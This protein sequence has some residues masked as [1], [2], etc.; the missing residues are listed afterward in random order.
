M[1]IA[2]VT[3]VVALDTLAGAQAI[4]DTIG[5]FKFTKKARENAIKDLERIICA[6]TITLDVEESK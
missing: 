2:M 1:K 4:G 3:L 6:Y 5:I